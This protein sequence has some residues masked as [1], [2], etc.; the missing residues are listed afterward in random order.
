MFIDEANVAAVLPNR[1]RMTW[2]IDL[3]TY[4]KANRGDFGVC[5][6]LS[7][8][9]C[10]KRN[11]RIH[12]KGFRFHGRFSCYFVV[13]MLNALEVYSRVEPLVWQPDMEN[14]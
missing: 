8:A 2:R 14:T 10:A 11:G 12:D 3:I 13:V 7:Q 6:K 4:P 9:G 1:R 5:R